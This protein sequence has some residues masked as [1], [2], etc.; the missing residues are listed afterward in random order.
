MP[1]VMCRLR[2]C[3]FWYLSSSQ[4]RGLRENGKT[5]SSR[6]WE[7][8][9]GAELA[10]QLA[11]TSFEFRVVV[12]QIGSCLGQRY[13]SEWAAWE[14]LLLYGY[15]QAFFLTVWMSV[16]VYVHGN[17]LI[18]CATCF[19]C[20]LK[21][22]SDRAPMWLFMQ[23]LVGCQKTCAQCAAEISACACVFVQPSVYT[24]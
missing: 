19:K 20:S 7:L 9:L 11:R 21:R 22:R 12:L 8:C 16:A 2:I 15:T 13:F 6:Q 23:A 3:S 14:I 18:G 24:E 4:L 10:S 5:T 1:T 17:G